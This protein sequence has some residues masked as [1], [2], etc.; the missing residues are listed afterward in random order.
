MSQRAEAG[1]MHRGVR[2]GGHVTSC[3][4]RM[5]KANTYAR[6]PKHPR[7]VHGCVV[8]WTTGEDV[9]AQDEADGEGRDRVV[10]PVVHR[11]GVN[12]VREDTRHDRLEQERVPLVDALAKL[13][14][15]HV[16]L[17]EQDTCER[18]STHRGS[19]RRE[20]IHMAA[21]F[22]YIVSGPIESP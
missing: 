20:E 12:G 3:V 6:Q 8:K 22:F 10:A 19:I 9:R 14:E 1:H 17:Q 13:D 2:R 7:R 4:Q 15:A 5:P 21:N 16:A 11:G 18:V